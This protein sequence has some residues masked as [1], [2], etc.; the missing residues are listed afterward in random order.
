AD[1]CWLPEKTAT[2][3]AVLENEPELDA[4]FGHAE[5]IL[6]TPAGEVSLDVLP[7]LHK[8][9]GLFRSSTFRQVGGFHPGMPDFIDWYARAKEAGRCFKMLDDVVYR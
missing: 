4:V 3:I 8:G 1:D 2:Q 5:R 6:M 7:G 9:A